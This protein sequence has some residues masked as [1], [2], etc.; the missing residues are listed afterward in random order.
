MY[1]PTTAGGHALYALDLLSA[2]SGTDPGRG[3]EVSLFTCSDLP[4]RY[5]PGSYGIHDLLPPMGPGSDFRSPVLRSL[6]RQ[7]YFL[8]RERAFVR[9]VSASP[10]IGA[11]HFQE[12][13]PWLMPGHF[14][15]LKRAG[16]RLFFTVH[17]V[18]PNRYMDGIPK[19]VYHRWCR[20][21]WRQCDALFVHTEGLRDTLRGFLGTPDPPIFVTPP[22]ISE[23]LPPG[24]PA[25]EVERAAD[26]RRLLFFGVIRPTKGLHVLLQAMRDLPDFRLTIAGD[27]KEAGYKKRILA[28]IDVLPKGQVRLMDRFVDD[29]EIPGIFARSGLL[30]LPYTFFH[31]QS[32]VLRLAMKYGIPVVGSD[33]GGLGESIRAWGIGCCA[34]PD[35]PASLAAGIRKMAAPDRYRSAGDA[36]ETVRNGLRWA[37]TAEQTWRAYLS[38][39]DALQPAGSGDTAG[40]RLRPPENP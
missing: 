1:T 31:A 36:V 25:G 37:N 28:E 9:S 32:G 8:K 24:K 34:E 12:Y 22:G 40:A 30:V 38:I 15:R 35:D 21:G 26:P 13:T 27:F 10:R 18:Y 23:H 14:K 20:D 2:L 39:L 16:L 33:V 6:C 17:G 11:V 5:R 4:P 7:W 19:G 3:L 29:E